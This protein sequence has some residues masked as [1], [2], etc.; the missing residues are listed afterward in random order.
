MKRPD[1][2][3]IVREVRRSI[4]RR[5][6]QRSEK[7]ARTLEQRRLRNIAWV[8]APPV[9]ALFNEESRR[10]TL[11]F[12]HSLRQAI[13]SGR[14]VGIDFLHARSARS[15][16]MLL[17]YAELYTILQRQ[18]KRSRIFVRESRNRKLNGVLKQVGVY[19]LCGHK[20][21][22][23][24]YGEDVVTWRAATGIEV[25]GE[26]YDHILGEYDG[27]LTESL[28]N[29]LYDGMAEAMTNCVHHAYIKPRYGSALDTPRDRRWWMF[30]TERDGLLSIVF[31]DL[32]CG[33]PQTLGARQ[34]S[35]WARLVAMGREVG[36]ETAIREAIQESRSRTQLAHRGKGLSQL[37]EAVADSSAGEILLYS[38]AGAYLQRAGKVESKAYKTSIS[39]TLVSWTVGLGTKNE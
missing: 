26:R 38:N 33:I 25:D 8:S 24:A 5:R 36:D 2:H 12:L 10:K 19:R 28:R 34:P 6:K 31:C 11:S 23:L 39:G 37:V 9:F 30:S 35:L 16:G 27:Q 18:T 32:G 14:A 29:G 1:R 22:L 3:F 21:K 15:D 4:R 17:F 13:R 20:C 7:I